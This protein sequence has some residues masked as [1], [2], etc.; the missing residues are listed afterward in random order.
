MKRGI[1]LGALLTIG[2]LSLTV[3]A[4]QQQGGAQPAPKVVT[5]D[6]IK[7]NKEEK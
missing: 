6:K 5:V 4:Y 3:T 1:V 2:G 7:D